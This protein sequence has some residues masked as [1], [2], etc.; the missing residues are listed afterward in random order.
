MYA[1]HYA[2]RFIH[3]RMVPTPLLLAETPGDTPQVELRE[4]N[5]FAS[6]STVHRHPANTRAIWVQR[7]MGTP[8]GNGEPTQGPGKSSQGVGEGQVR[9]ST[10]QVDSPVKE[11]P[12]ASPSEVEAGETIANMCSRNKSV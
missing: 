5:P 7:R 1:T 12:M 9:S 6:H 11:Q 3:K 2:I 10:D 8:S 4:H